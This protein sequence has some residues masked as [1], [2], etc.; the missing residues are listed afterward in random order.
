MKPEE[1]EALSFKI[2]DQE[3]GPHSFPSEQWRILQRMIHTSADFGYM[4]TIRFHPEA[5]SAGLNAIQKGKTIITDTN[6]ARV[7]IRKGDAGRFGSVLKCY[8]NDPDVVATSAK[9]GRT[10]AEIAVEAA[11]SE[12]EGGIYV[13]G[14]APTALL[15]LIDLVR[16]KKANPALIIGLPVGFVNAVESKTALLDMDYPHISNTSR[17]GGSNIAAS[18]VNAL[19]KLLL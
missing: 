16:E 8:I 12:M 2:I 14:N 9:T 13:V 6:M 10:R 1:I 4:D 18:V 11:V 5:I 15:R 7:G 3:A 19:A 17:K